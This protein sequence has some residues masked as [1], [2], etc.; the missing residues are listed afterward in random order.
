MEDDNDGYNE[1]V[2]DHS[3]MLLE[4]Y[5]EVVEFPDEIYV[6]VLDDDYQD[7]EEEYINN[8]NFDDVSDEFIRNIYNDDGKE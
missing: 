1:W 6:G 5:S 4:M 3:V 8:L 7:A 2:H